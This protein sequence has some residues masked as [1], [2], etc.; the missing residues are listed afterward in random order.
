MLFTS[1]QFNFANNLNDKDKYKK[2]KIIFDAV[3][4][5][6][7][8]EVRSLVKIVKVMTIMPDVLF[9]GLLQKFRYRATNVAFEF[10]ITNFHEFK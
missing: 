4:G 9:E 1:S 3:L 8:D 5:K 10:I 2:L 7:K 6:T